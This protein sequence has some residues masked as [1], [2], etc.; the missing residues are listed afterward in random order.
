MSGKVEAG[1]VVTEVTLPEPPDATT[2]SLWPFRR[3]PYQFLIA[4]FI[5]EAVLWGKNITHPLIAQTCMLIVETQD[6]Y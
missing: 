4:A 1:I 3:G 6:L 5:I 2:K